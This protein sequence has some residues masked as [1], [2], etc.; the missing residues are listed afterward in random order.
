MCLLY[1]VAL[2]LLPRKLETL[3][4]NPHEFGYERSISVFEVKITA[5]ESDTRHINDIELPEEITSQ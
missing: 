3:K 5:I 2:E 1:E 4:G